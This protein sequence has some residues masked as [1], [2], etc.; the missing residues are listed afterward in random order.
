M[1]AAPVNPT[2]STLISLDTISTEIKFVSDFI[3]DL[4]G[5]QASPSDKQRIIGLL[6]SEQ[7]DLAVAAERAIAALGQDPIIG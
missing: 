6:A 5:K 4:A 2:P 1:A 3:E 7:L